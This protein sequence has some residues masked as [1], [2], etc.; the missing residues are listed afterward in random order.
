MKELTKEYNQSIN[1]FADGEQFEHAQRVAKVFANSDLVPESFKN[2]V[3]NCIIAIEMASRIKASPLM[4]MQNMHIV[5]GK[6]SWASTFLIACINKSGL[7]TPLRYETNS[8]DEG[9]VRAYAKDIET[10]DTCKG[11]WV[12]IKMAKV[13]G[14][15]DRKGSKWNTMPEL[16]L[17]YRAAAF[18]QRQ[19]CPEISMGFHTTE[20]IKDVRVKSITSEEN[21]KQYDRIKKHIEESQDIEYLQMVQAYVKEYGLVYEYEEKAK[22]L[23][24]NSI[25]EVEI[26]K[27]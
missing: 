5:R 23:K 6:P 14:W 13:E 2:N 10:G 19:F 22:E 21:E 24:S 18:F 12:S 15:I 26:I 17:R 4:V 9:S 1:I 16:M 27:E 25:D 8:K 7:F 11:A 3:G 20:E